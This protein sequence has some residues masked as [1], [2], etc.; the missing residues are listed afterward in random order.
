M[1]F[2]NALI[3]LIINTFQQ[4]IFADENHEIYKLKAKTMDKSFTRLLT[5]WSPNHNIHWYSNEMLLV[6]ATQPDNLSLTPSITTLLSVNLTGQI[7]PIKKIATT[8]ICIDRNLGVVLFNSIN[9]EGNRES[10]E[11]RVT[12]NSFFIPKDRE[13]AQIQ[14][15]SCAR[16]HDPNYPIQEIVNNDIKGHKTI[17]T[18]DIR[19]IKT[20]KQ[21]YIEAF[22]LSK[23]KKIGV[24]TY[25]WFFGTSMDAVN[26][27][28]YDVV[29]VSENEILIYPKYDLQIKRSKYWRDRKAITIWKINKNGKIE[30]INIPWNDLYENVIYKIF[31]F[32]DYIYIALIAK[33]NSNKT[34]IYKIENGIPDILHRSEVVLDSIVI[35]PNGQSVAFVE[36]QNLT[37]RF[38]ASNDMA[39]SK[40]FVYSGN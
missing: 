2:L 3:G 38:N 13:K 10:I 39:Y 4:D 6:P 5:D 20:D 14:L 17:L 15:Q 22:D 21:Q 11:W 34:G 9:S 23:N 37:S 35:S 30:A 8:A 27:F 7:Q 28:D 25:E 26:S 24:I 40:L 12:S 36:R 31:Y 29:Q 1:F 33:E 19:F 18:F 32:K 16:G